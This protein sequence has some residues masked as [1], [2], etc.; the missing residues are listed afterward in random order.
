MFYFKG[1][2]RDKGEDVK[3]EEIIL[4]EK[5]QGQLEGFYDEMSIM[6]KK[7]SNDGVNKFKLKFINQLFSEL[8]TFLKDDYKPFKEF[9]KFDED[10]LPTN[11]DVVLIL[12][13]YL[14]CMEKLRGDNIIEYM[15]DWYWKVNN[16]KSFIR[17][18]PPKK[19]KEK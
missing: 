15:Q 18:A 1:L 9:I 14:N 2:A 12:S 7:S 4:F 17:T 10:E 8:N 19:I 5:L 16:E 13:Q 11:S 6:S 3:E